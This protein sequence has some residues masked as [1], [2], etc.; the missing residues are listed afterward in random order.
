LLFSFVDISFKVVP[1]LPKAFKK[2]LTF[3]IESLS[4]YWSDYKNIKRLFEFNAITNSMKNI[5]FSDLKSINQLNPIKNTVPS[6]LKKKSDHYHIE[7]EK[8]ICFLFF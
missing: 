3:E 5:S 6:P 4:K 7:L 2:S 8:L 1:N